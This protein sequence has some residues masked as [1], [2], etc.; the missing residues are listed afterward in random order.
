M[1]QNDVNDEEESVDG[2]G[3]M[4]S[5]HLLIRDPDTGEVVA[6]IR[7]SANNNRDDFE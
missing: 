4:V 6:S 3:L 1:N 2:L 5:D 7:G